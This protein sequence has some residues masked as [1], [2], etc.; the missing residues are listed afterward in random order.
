MELIL[1]PFVIYYLFELVFR[2]P[3]CVRAGGATGGTG[4]P[5]LG[6]LCEGRELGQWP[7]LHVSQHAALKQLGAHKTPVAV[8]LHQL[9]DLQEGREGKERELVWV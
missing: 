9:E 8:K 5:S 6:A 2:R 7:A 4:V 1:L 3:A